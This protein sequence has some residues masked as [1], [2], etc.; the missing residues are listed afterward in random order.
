MPITW[1]DE[2][3]IDG[4]VI[5]NDHKSLIGLIND[6]EYIQAGPGLPKQVTVILT[7]LA[8][9]AQAHFEREER[10]QSAVGYPLRDPHHFRHM[11]LMHEL[12]AMHAEWQIA[13][14]PKDMVAFHVR[15]CDFLRHWLMSHVIKDDLPMRPYVA[16][17]RRHA[18]GVGSLDEA[19]QAQAP[20]V[21]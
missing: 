5:D 3:S 19:V 8:A 13:R 10:L 7:R 18:D 16:E 2:M 14:A 11:A 20:P 21:I 15:L 1:R 4:G 17:M 9:Y 6:V 12:D